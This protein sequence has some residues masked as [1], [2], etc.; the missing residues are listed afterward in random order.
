MATGSSVTRHLDLGAFGEED[1]GHLCA[2]ESSFRLGG[3]ELGAQRWHQRRGGSLAACGV[4]LAAR[5]R[6]ACISGAGCLVLV[7]TSSATS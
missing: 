5:R 4:A 3:A 1:S 7:A 6:L 2:L